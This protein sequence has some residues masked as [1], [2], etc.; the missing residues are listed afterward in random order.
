MSDIENSRDTI[1]P[2]AYLG[3]ELGHQAATRVGEAGGEL[4][5]R[6]RPDGTG[7][8]ARHGCRR[9]GARLAHKYNRLTVEE[10]L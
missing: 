5:R 7:D 3:A 10:I 8:E 1:S 6:P 9:F 4:P 2:F